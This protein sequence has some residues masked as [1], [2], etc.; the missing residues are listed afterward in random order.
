MLTEFEWLM[1]NDIILSINKAENTDDMRRIFIMSLKAVINFEK[2]VFYLAECKNSEISLFSPQYIGADKEFFDNY[3]KNYCSIDYAGSFISLMKTM[4][5]RDTDLMAENVRQQ[6]KLYKEFLLP[7]RIPY[8]GGIVFAYNYDFIAD[9]I[10]YKTAEQGDFT[11]KEIYIL[12]ILK[13]HVHNRLLFFRKYDTGYKGEK[14]AKVNGLS[15]GLTP[16]EVEVVNLILV[17]STNSDIAKKLCISAATVKKHISNIFQKLCV[18]N[19]VQL[20]NL[21][22]NNKNE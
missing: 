17:G 10:L 3:E 7:N 8:A 18:N 1:L 9:L 14:I 12:N 22:M 11:D 21:I 19:K 6:T 16:R 4:A 2:G 15:L 20:I 5:Y 13:D